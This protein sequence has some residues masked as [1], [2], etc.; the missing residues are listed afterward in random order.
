MN[1]KTADV[2]NHPIDAQTID[3]TT[4]HEAVELTR[5]RN[6][7]RGSMGD[8]ATYRGR[9]VE[10]VRP[11]DLMARSSAR[12]AGAGI[13]FQSELHRR[14]RAAA[15]ESTRRLAERAR[16]LPPLSAFGRGATRPDAGRSPIGT[17]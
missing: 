8:P 3:V 15:Q 14:T 1:E 4:R 5:L 9:G 7:R 2:S 6:Q 10:W 11:T 16:H 12:V 13:N 17:A